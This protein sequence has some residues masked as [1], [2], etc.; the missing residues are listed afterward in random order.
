[1]S[2]SQKSAD[3]NLLFGILALQMDFISREALIKGMQTWVFDKSRRLGEIFA[4]L[5]VLSSERCALLDALV[6][7][8]L[9]QHDNDPVKSLAAV[10][11]IGSA[12]KALERLA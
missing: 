1:M 3:C 7:E 11:S 12:R 8:H 6:Q 9:R 5:G 10:S 4:G 2:T